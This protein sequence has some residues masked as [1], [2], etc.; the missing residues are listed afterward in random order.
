MKLVLITKYFLPDSSVDSISSQELIESL[1]KRNSNLDIHVVTTNSLYKS[2]SKQIDYSFGS[3][4]LHQIETIYSGQNKFFAFMGGLFDGLRMVLKAKSLDVQSIISLT[5]PPLI[6]LWCALFL[7]DK[8]WLYWTF[9]LFP[10]AL[11]A[12]GYFSKRNII[13]KFLDYSVYRTPPSILI[14]LGKQ[15][16]NYLINKYNKYIPHI[17]L[18]CGIIPKESKS[19]ELYPAWYQ[20][21]KKYIGYLGNIGQAHSKDFLICIINH[22]H[23]LE[24]YTL[25]LALYGDYKEIIE[26]YLMTNKVENILLVPKVEREHLYLIDIHLVSLLEDWTNISVP[27]KAVSAVCSGSALMFYGSKRSDTWFMFDECG[28]FVDHLEDIPTMLGSV[29]S[30]SINIKQNASLRVAIELRSMQ[31]YAYDQILDVIC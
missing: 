15:Q 11:L 21:T 20:K 30:A 18:P 5:N 6:S 19:T 14:T 1:L 24:G 7:K 8:K 29:S 17:E 23:R 26:Q 3:Y 2:N 13:Y 9:D 25:I 16:Y 28:F 10:D 31:S 27:S 12:G 22:L 4:K